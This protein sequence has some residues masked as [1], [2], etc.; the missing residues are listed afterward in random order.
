[1]KYLSGMDNL[2]LSQETPKQ[3]MHVGG[4]GIY[5]PSTAEGGFVRFKSI[6]EFFTQRLS[7]APVFRRRLEHS[8]IDL[9][10]P[11]W[12]EDPDVD[13]EYH[14]RHLALPE[15]GD[16]RQLMIQIARIHAR[17]MDLSKPLWEAY[18]IEGLDNIKG[19]P[20][21]SFALYM[22][23]HH[24]AVD[25]EAGAH[26]IG[27]LHTLSPEY[28]DK[29]ANIGAHINSRLPDSTEIISKS[30]I[31]RVKQL[32][33]IGSMGSTVTNYALKNAKQSLSGGVD[34]IKDLITG[35]RSSKAKRPDT[36][37]NAPISAHRS[38][39]AVGL[40]LADCS[41]IRKNAGLGTVNDIF[42]TVVGG[43][44]RD[45][46]ASKGEA[47][48]GSLLGAMPM[49]LRGD[50]KSG[51]EGNQIAQAYYNLHSDIVDPV[52]RLAA[53]VEE[54]GQLKQ[55]MNTGLGKDFQAR[56]LEILPA[57]LVAKM[58]TKE[59]GANSNG[60]VS[61][62]RGPNQ[63]LYMAGAKLERFI[64]F[65]IALD[66]C[67]LNITGFSYNGILWVAVTCC[68]QMMPDPEFFCECIENNLKDLKHAAGKKGSEGSKPRAKKVSKK[69]SQGPKKKVAKKKVAKKKVAKK[70]S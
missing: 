29:E 26:L 16:W 38:L 65:S 3:Y 19:L 68:R 40:S 61:N 50:D 27:N 21:G 15:P 13:V 30:L 70:G 23:F 8:L 41:E 1:M 67:G 20:P 10:R 51:D 64:P 57:S 7:T 37:F 53:I 6:I 48:D 35:I 47:P 17:P 12:V 42:V 43:A 62:V 60:N 24:S 9:D 2:F 31:R 55:K 18:I 66:G 63:S 54:M 59:V 39:D 14:V 11:F 58:I 69:S 32:K 49:T 56:L 4:L 46:L 33:D 5:N 52:A 34:G 44:I 25:G 45:Y 28:V 36:R 22:K